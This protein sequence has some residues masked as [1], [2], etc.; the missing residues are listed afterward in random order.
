MRKRIH[1]TYFLFLLCMFWAFSLPV[2]AQTLHLKGTVTDASTQEG[3]IG[4][5]IKIK[6]TTRGCITDID[7]NFT[8]NDVSA[9]AVLVVSS[10]G[11]STQEEIGRAHV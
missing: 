9:K 10:I 7:G 4:A 11:Y 8:L 1:R 3:L 6:G 5:N 2:T